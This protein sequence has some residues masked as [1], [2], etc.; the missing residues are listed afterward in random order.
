MKKVNYDQVSKSY[1]SR[2][3]TGLVEGIEKAISD[4][5]LKIQVKSVLDVGCG[6]GAY[7]EI[8]KNDIL[9]YGLD[10]SIGM[11]SKAMERMVSAA[12][13]KGTSHRLP[14]LSSV[15]DL[16]TCIHALH[17]F[18]HKLA[19]LKEAKRVLRSDSALAIIS[20]DPHRGKD[21]WYVY[22]YFPEIPNMD[23]DRYPSSEEII[24][25]LGQAGFI[26]CK[27]I[28]VHRFLF[29][30]QGREIFDDP[31]FSRQGSSQFSLLS[32][33]QWDRGVVRIKKEI[34]EAEE[35][36]REVVFEMDVSIYM[37]IGYSK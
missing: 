10:N 1:D 25:W 17:H 4:L 15:F 3:R 16:V 6:T 21:K 5:V 8:F 33:K 7:L 11:L 22:K 24:E 34:E 2:Y 28:P 18:D 12:F 29:S 23:L 19:F 32:D 13:I 31:V 37:N 14:F 36:G 35:K 30:Y 27:N 20:M 26:N 9:S